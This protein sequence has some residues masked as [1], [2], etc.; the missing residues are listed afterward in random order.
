M[1]VATVTTT[2]RLDPKVYEAMQKVGEKTGESFTRLVGKA[3]A[4][5]AAMAASDAVARKIENS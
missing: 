4:E 1:P 5:F 3:C 2:V